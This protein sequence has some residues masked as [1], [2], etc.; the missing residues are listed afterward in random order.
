M[1]KKTLLNKIFVLLPLL[2]LSF[3]QPSF[4]DLLVGYK[5]TD[6]NSTLCDYNKMWSCA[7]E[8]LG[9]VWKSFRTQAVEN[10]IA[11]QFIVFIASTPATYAEYGWA[12]YADNNG[13]PGVTIA[14]GANPFY[15]F[16]V[17]ENILPAIDTGEI[18]KGRNYWITFHSSL[19]NQVQIQRAR[20]SLTCPTS[21]KMGTNQ[22]PYGNYWENYPPPPGDKFQNTYGNDCYAWG[23]YSVSVPPRCGDGIINQSVEQCEVGIPCVDSNYTC[24]ETSCFCQPIEKCYCDC[25]GAEIPCQ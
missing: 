14:W 15:F 7:P 17:G 5:Y 16:S 3:A 8:A 2:L 10:G 4:G 24:L 23:V 20:A 9:C 22:C 12:V 13:K 1:N 18:I 19:G 25:C 11:N 21:L 6:T